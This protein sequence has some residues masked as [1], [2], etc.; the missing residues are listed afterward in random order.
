[1]KDVKTS[2][3]LTAL[4]SGLRA[5]VG[6]AFGT[7]SSTSTLTGTAGFDVSEVEENNLKYNVVSLSGNAEVADPP[8][9]TLDALYTQSK[10]LKELDLELRWKDIPSG[11]EIE[12]VSSTGK[13]NVN[14]RG[15]SGSSNFGISDTGARDG[16]TVLKISVW[17]K[18]PKELTADST[19]TMTLSSIED[20]DSGPARK[21][22]LEKL[23]I[24]LG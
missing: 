11:S 24:N 4:L 15:I 20:S 17:V 12:I 14:R 2:L 16:D 23:G 6:T 19:I 3:T 21:I 10:V 18:D 8:L 13:L 9:A 5:S 1:M 22:P 7:I